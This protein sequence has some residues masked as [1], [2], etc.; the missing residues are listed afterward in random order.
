MGEIEELFG[1]AAA[2]VIAFAIWNNNAMPGLSS[3]PRPGA[4]LRTWI[5]AFLLRSEPN[6]AMIKPRLVCG[7][8]SR[9]HNNSGGETMRYLPNFTQN[10][11]YMRE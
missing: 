11:E 1:G 9:V 8:P 10:T 6:D 4:I 5:H 2:A 3:R 7:W